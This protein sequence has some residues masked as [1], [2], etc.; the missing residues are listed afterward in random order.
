MNPGISLPF[1]FLLSGLMAMQPWLASS[2][3][4]Q[5]P[6]RERIT[7]AL[8]R[9]LTRR[10]LAP[11]PSELA[12]GRART[13]MAA[14]D[15]ATAYKDYRTAADSAR[16][17]AGLEK[18]RA[19]AVRGLCESGVKLALQ[20][21]AQGKIPEAEQ[22]LREILSAPYNPRYGP[23]L[24]LLATLRPTAAPR[25]QGFTTTPPPI[26]VAPRIQGFT[27]TPPPTTIAPPRI[28]GD[29]NTRR[30]TPPPAA[31][32]PPDKEIPTLA[33]P[34][35]VGA[36][37]PKRDKSR[38]G[39]PAT[40]PAASPAASVQMKKP[41]VN[42]YF[43][44]DRL[45]SG[46]SGPSN[47]FGVDWNKAR[48]PL[49]TGVVTVSIPPGHKEGQVERPGTFLY[50]WERP[51]DVKKHFV[52]TKIRPVKGD[53]FYGELRHEFEQRADADRSAFVYIHGFNVKFD[54]AAYATA[55]IAYDLD[56][57]GVPM[58]FSWPSQGS[59]LA[60]NGDQDTVD[61]S[62]PNLQGFL[63]RVARETGALRIHVMAHSMGN[64]LLTRALEKLV[65]QA[66]IQPLF[67]NVIMASPDV[68]AL[69]FTGIWPQIKVAAK[70]FTLYA[71]SDDKALIA[72][73]KAKG[74]QDF[75]RLGE[76]GPNIMV[77]PGL[78]TID[79][80]GID[81]SLLGHSYEA[82]CKP[83]RDDLG[84]LIGKG[85]APAERK[86]PPR[87]SNDGLAYW[88]FP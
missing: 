36:A 83:V 30:A 5:E 26:T 49:I 64:R 11:S 13:A 72:S 45:P 85:F 20:R 67:E 87:R 62:S 80:S 60:Y 28:A 22:I 78:D 34:R 56:F 69:V 86:L 9:D 15:F 43:G 75:T 88:A 35:I 24:E 77:I 84:L 7:P 25:I 39:P 42:V 63:E 74:G 68:N 23:A 55:Q 81:T 19:E 44:T 1:L 59:V 73:R 31:T 17:V 27:S 8:T 46:A 66:D 18:L 4:A 70:R 33:E 76:G 52:L 71:S 54:D 40:T 10:P 6:R 14:Q 41:L 12:L 82:S 21:K 61:F 48:D 65:L 38:D 57:K 3:R 51:E 32:V 29:A 16:G 58:M 47:Y 79:A 37:P 2:V 50:F 53:D